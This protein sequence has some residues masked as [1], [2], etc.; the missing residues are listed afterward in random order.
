MRLLALL[1]LLMAYPGDGET[2]LLVGGCAHGE[3]NI[4]AL[5]DLGLG[6]FVWIPASVYAT[7]NVPWDEENTTLRDVEVAVRNDMHFMVS[8][9]RGLGDTLRPGGYQYGGHQGALHKHV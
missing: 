3:T 1:S 6:N 2:P 8:V 7:S 9:R 4:Q 5:A